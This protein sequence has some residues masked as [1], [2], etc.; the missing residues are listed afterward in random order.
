[1]NQEAYSEKEV[2]A[3]IQEIK[4]SQRMLSGAD[5][6]K[7]VYKRSFETLKELMIHMNQQVL[8]HM[9]AQKYKVIDL[10]NTIKLLVRCKQLL[11][12][13]KLAFSTLQTILEFE[14][15]TQH[16]RRNVDKYLESTPQ[17]TTLTK[18]RTDAEEQVL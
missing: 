8:F 6:V 14:A 9:I 16:I 11:L 15:A 4:E 3:L 7:T 1:M 5:R 2:F 17:S 18:I 12:S 10:D 13:R